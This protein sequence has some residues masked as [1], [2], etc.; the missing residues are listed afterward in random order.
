MLLSRLQ[1]QK[2][3]RTVVACH[4]GM[5]DSLEGMLAAMQILQPMSSVVARFHKL[6]TVIHT[7]SQIHQSTI[8][9]CAIC[10]QLDP[11]VVRLHIAMRSPLTVKCQQTLQHQRKSMTHRW[12]I[13][14]KVP[15]NASLASRG[16]SRCGMR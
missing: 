16:R 10:C 8:G 12:I 13:V 3:P 7:P 6:T 1:L 5:T 15:M 4:A 9:K 14:S 11:D 2:P